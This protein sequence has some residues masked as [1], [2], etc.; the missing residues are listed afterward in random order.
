MLIADGG[1]NAKKLLEVFDRAGKQAEEAGAKVSADSFNGLTLHVVAFPKKEARKGRK[2]AA[3]SP[4]RM[5]QR[6]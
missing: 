5:D 4:A 1:E 6:R 3:A 2:G